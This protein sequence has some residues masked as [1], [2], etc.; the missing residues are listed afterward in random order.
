MVEANPRRSPQSTLTVAM[1]TYNGAQHLSEQLE[2]IVRQTRVPD[3]IVICDDSSSD[4][5]VSMLKDFAK[6]SPC[7]VRLFVNRDRLGVTKNFEKAI[8]LATGDVIALADQDDVWYPSKLDKL[9]SALRD[10]GLAFSDADVVGEALQ[11]FGYSLWETVGFQSTRVARGDGVFR[12][13][14]RGNV[15][16]GASLAFRTQ[17]R[18]LVLPIPDSWVHDAWI[19][20][21]VAAVAT[22][23]WIEEPLLAYRQHGTNQIGGRQES[24]AARLRRNWQDPQYQPGELLSQFEEALI[25]L[26]SYRNVKG[27]KLEVIQ[28]VVEKISH[29]ERRR[30]VAETPVVGLGFLVAEASRMGYHHYSKG[31]ATVGKDAFL[32]FR[33]CLGR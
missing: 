14:L 3:E 10:A 21:L 30:F 18:D 23:T 27:V 28:Q 1:C 16:M 5:T 20:L 33:K 17:F 15:V 25:R 13:L 11:P 2:S 12:H 9:E 8:D 24:L 19:A 26:D 4:S 31:W 22:V 6:A 7:P 29:L 32:N